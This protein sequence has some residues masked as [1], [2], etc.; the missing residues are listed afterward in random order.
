MIEMIDTLNTANSDSKNMQAI[1]EW[2]VIKKD[3]TTT[4][5]GIISVGDN[6]GVVH[7]C[8]IDE[9]LRGKRVCY[10]AENKHFTYE[11]FTFVKYSE[12]YGVIE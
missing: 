6:T 12:V 10:N 5:S 7:D 4:A 2:V 11:E 3:T 8:K 1:G 9:T